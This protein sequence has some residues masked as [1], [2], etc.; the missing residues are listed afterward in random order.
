M[1]LPD[2]TPRAIKTRTENAKKKTQPEE[3]EAK[4]DDG[5]VVPCADE[6]PPAETEAQAENAAGESE[7]AVAEAEGGNE[8]PAANEE[9]PGNATEQFDDLLFPTGSEKP[10]Q[11][12][13]A[14][15]A[16]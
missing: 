16:S 3:A 15:A 1:P 5:K 14:E 11:P 12:E 8:A 9:P 2:G 7:T 10:G 6:P 13:E 4:A